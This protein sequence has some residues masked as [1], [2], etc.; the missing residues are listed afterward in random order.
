[1]P[2]AS[3]ETSKNNIFPEETLSNLKAM[4]LLALRTIRL[5]Y[6]L[7]SQLTKGVLLRYRELL[8]PVL[9]HDIAR[10]SLTSAIF[11]KISAFLSI[12]RI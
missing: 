12:N 11:T 6:R 10:R 4:S 7:Y 1:L 5:S 3:P 9:Y 8:L 2:S